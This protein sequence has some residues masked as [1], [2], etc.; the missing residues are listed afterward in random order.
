MGVAAAEERHAASGSYNS[1]LRGRTGRAMFFLKLLPAI[2]SLLLLFA[3]GFRDFGP[4]VLPFTGIFVFFLVPQG[5]VARFFQFL[6]CFGALEW[7]RMAVF[8]AMERQEKGEAWLRLV[9]ILGATS[10]FTLWAAILFE[11]DELREVYPRR[12]IM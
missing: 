5:W 3:H 1:S 8:L 7:V 12:P 2:V 10:A 11:S 4:I 9:L 6:L